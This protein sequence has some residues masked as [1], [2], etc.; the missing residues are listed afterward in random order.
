MEDLSQKITEVPKFFVG[1]LFGRHRHATYSHGEGQDGQKP[2]QAKEA[3]CLPGHLRFC[4][5]SGA[6]LQSVTQ[7]LLRLIPQEKRDAIYA[8]LHFHVLQCMYI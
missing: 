2:L 5:D 1:V 3:H 4:K 6:L 7:W 8:H